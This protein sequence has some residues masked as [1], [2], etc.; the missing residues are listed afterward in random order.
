MAAIRSLRN[1][2]WIVFQHSAIVCAAAAEGVIMW[3]NIYGSIQH[4]GLMD[5]LYDY[6]LDITLQQPRYCDRNVEYYNPHAWP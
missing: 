2:D 1:F 6:E 5:R 4:L 3:S